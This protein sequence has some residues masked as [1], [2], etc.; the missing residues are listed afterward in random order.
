VEYHG[1][2]EGYGKV[3]IAI[4]VYDDTPDLAAEYASTHRSTVPAAAV[5]RFLIDG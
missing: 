2:N 3:D 1:G 5:N 4:P